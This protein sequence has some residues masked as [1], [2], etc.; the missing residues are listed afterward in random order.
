WAL[1][2]PDVAMFFDCADKADEPASIQVFGGTS[3]AAPFAA[4]AAALVI[5][6]Y[7]ATHRGAKPSPALIKRILTSTATD[8]NDPADRQG[9]GLLNS[10]Q[11]VL[12][13]G[14]IQDSQGTPPP[15][16]DNLLVD[17][18]QLSITA[19]QGAQRTIP[20]RVT[21]VG[22]NTQTVTAHNRVLNRTVSDER[23]S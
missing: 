19:A 10:L 3:Q 1:C 15:K 2:S 5:E 4:G 13:A 7:A 23:G 8:Q 21:N 17:R 16:G 12:A 14:S 11:A 9:A 22:A 18:T 20:L 6:A